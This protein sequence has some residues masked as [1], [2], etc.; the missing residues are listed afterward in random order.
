MIFKTEISPLDLTLTLDCGQTFRWKEL[1]RGS[2]TGIVGKYQ[3]TLRQSARSVSINASTEDNS[4]VRL[5]REYLRA[6]DDVARIQRAL[7]KDEVLVR[8]MKEYRGLRIVKMDEWECLVSYTL[9]TY[10]NIP[11]IKKMI[12]TLCTKYG[13]PIPGGAHAF[14]TIKRLG[15][16]SEK[17]LER[18]GLGYRAKYVTG[19]CDS[20][21]PNEMKSMTR[22]EYPD[23]KERLLELDGVGE[24][25]S[26]CV[27]LFGFGKLE[28]FPIDIWI[29]R[30]LGRL[31]HVKG[32]Y[33]R[34]SEFASERFG[35]YSGYAQ[36]Y[37]Y[38]NERSAAQE[39]ACAFSEVR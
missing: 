30:A 35:E 19:L 15:E 38:F 23:L 31:Y 32:S 29:E 6:D 9:A 4:V 34:L 17:E 2:W 10:A 3:L 7:A 39:D 18:C 26:D 1:E 13:E 24:K 28:A 22:L 21:T 36:E 20:L 5:V 37:L 27:S 25:V 16:A 12:D 8:G 33:R 11:R 14:P